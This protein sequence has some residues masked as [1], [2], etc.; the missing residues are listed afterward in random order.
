MSNKN[1][2]GEFRSAGAVRVKAFGHEGASRLADQINE[3]I[4]DSSEC[5]EIL[6]VSMVYEPK[7]AY[8]SALVTY[9]PRQ[10]WPI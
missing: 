1:P 6:G 5:P 7:Y 4:D 10:E 9:R 8:H 3:W 2:R